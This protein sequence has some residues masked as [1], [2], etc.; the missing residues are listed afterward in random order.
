MQIYPFHYT[1]AKAPWCNGHGLSLLHR[2]TW[3]VNEPLPWSTHALR[4]KLCSQD[5][6]LHQSPAIQQN[7]EQKGNSSNTSGTIDQLIIN[8]MVMDSA[9]KKK[10]N[11]STACIDY[12][13]SVPHDWIV[14]S[15]TNLIKP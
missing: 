11:I 6:N 3:R 9:K 13:N 1:T 14:E 5:I 4:G 2:R 8:K 7:T 12:R 15:Y 10:C